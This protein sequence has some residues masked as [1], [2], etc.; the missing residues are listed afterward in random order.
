M[1]EL[2][3]GNTVPENNGT[4]A[5]ET[6]VAQQ[7][8]SVQPVVATTPAP[9]QQT[10]EPGFIK[11]NWKKIAVGAGAV[12]T[13][14]GSAFV[15]YKKGKQSGYCAGVDTMNQLNSDGSVSP[16]DPNVE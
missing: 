3:N 1:S 8:P 9:V 12:L 11:R 15:A 5:G 14:V 6:P 7:N 4:V 16:L 10:N 13:A 2:N